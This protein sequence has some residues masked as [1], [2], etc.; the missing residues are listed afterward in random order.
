MGKQW[1]QWQTW[2]LGGSKITADGDWG[3]KIKTC[4]LLGRKAVTNLDS[5]LKNRG[6]TLL[7]KLH[8]V[9]CMV[10]PVVMYGCECW[11]IKK[12]ECQRTDFWAVV[13]EKTLESPLDYKIKPVNSRRNQSWLFIRRT[14]GETEALILWPPDAKNQ[15]IRKD[16]DAGND[17]WEEEKGTPED[18]MIGWHHL[19][20]G[21][22]FVQASVDGEGQGSLACCSSWG[23]QES[24]TAEQLNNSNTGIIL[25]L[26]EAGV[27]VDL[28]LYMSGSTQG[29][30]SGKVA[31]S[32][33]IV[34]K[35]PIGR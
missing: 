31:C 5:V 1:K 29:S 2:F 8:V 20:N 33:S 13:L 12:A 7:T 25:R 4:L 17:W 23:C 22:E 27:Q 14:D 34:S 32:A 19:L 21:H 28:F 9:K 30:V 6:I 24:D 11:T 15:L 3:H 26:D 10:F 16:S 18:K 35:S